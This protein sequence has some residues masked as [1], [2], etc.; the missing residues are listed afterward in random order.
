[1]GKITK[2][3]PE[4]SAQFEAWTKKWIEIGLSTEPAD[5]DA[6]TDAALRGYRYANLRKP[7]VVLRMASPYAATLGGSLAVGL[8]TELKGVR[9]QVES[10]VDSQVRNQV[11]NQVRS[12]VRSQVWSQVWSQVRN[13]V[14]N[15]VVSQVESQVDSQ[16]RSGF[17]NYGCSG[18]WAS[19]AAYISFFRDVVGWD[20]PVLEKFCVDEALVKSCGWTWWHE[21]VL[22]IS[23]RPKHIERD[24]QGRLH[25]GSRMAIE[26]RDGWGL[27]CWHGT[28]LDDGQ[29]WIITNP[30]RITAALIDA[31]HNSEIKRV[32][33]ERFGYERYIKETGATVV[34]EAPADHPLKGARTARLL[35]KDTGE[36]EP[37]CMVDALNSTPEPDGTTKRYM[38]LVDP[39][40][41][42]GAASSD[43][44]AALASTW[45]NADGSLYFKRPSDYRP[46]F[47]S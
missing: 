15:Q 2:I 37:I 34:D 25:S 18:L 29:A 8:L 30:E 7:M 44:V 38:M 40:A 16:V 32:M 1:M 5:F 45:R 42:D 23:D 13:Q 19:W 22:A 31:E 43:V 46:A 4:Q 26:Y 21:N 27:Y 6:A 10:Q 17:Y 35:V 47:E 41:Y 12:Q 20:D 24:A 9:S 11:R 28:R 14:W 33:L 3:T 36:E 39:K